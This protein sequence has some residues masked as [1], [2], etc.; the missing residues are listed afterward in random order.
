MKLT[1]QQTEKAFLVWQN[2]VDKGEKFLNASQE[3]TQQELDQKRR[4]T[5]PEVAGLMNRFL[6]GEIPLEEF[7][8]A[9]DGINKRNRL[10]GFQAINGQMFF[11]V[12][13]KTSIAGG[14]RDEFVTLLKRVIPK[15]LSIDKA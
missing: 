8:T 14:Q 1:N 13:T 3:Y 9:N 6:L 12:L 4:K 5:I 11:N 15:P 10:W 7:K 2:Y